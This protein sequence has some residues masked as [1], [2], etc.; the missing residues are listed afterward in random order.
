MAGQGRTGK[1]PG[2]VSPTFQLVLRPTIPGPAK[3]AVNVTARAKEAHR[4]C[5]NTQAENH[6]QGHVEEQEGAGPGATGRQTHRH[7]G[8][9]SDHAV[10]VASERQE[11]DGVRPTGGGE[12]RNA[13]G[14]ET[15]AADRG[16]EQYL[17]HLPK[18]G[19]VR[20]SKIRCR[21]RRS[22]SRVGQTPMTHEYSQTEQFRVLVS[23]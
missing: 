1:L 9:Q 21:S 6:L 4:R 7:C 16:A 12:F 23:T 8:R 15:D 5:G 3:Q 20:F 19:K 14:P 10:C 11:A 2:D 17:Q 22:T 13:Q 18:G